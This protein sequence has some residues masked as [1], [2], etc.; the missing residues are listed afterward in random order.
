MRCNSDTLRIPFCFA[1][2]V[3]NW[4]ITS[5]SVYPMSARRLQLLRA[6]SSNLAGLLSL[7]AT[8]GMVSPVTAIVLEA[9]NGTLTG[10]CHA[11]T[12]VSGYSGTGYVTGFQSAN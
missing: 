7:I 2:E 5:V 11:T 4:H 10:N 1:I 9:E 12:A 8:F 3:V 6:H